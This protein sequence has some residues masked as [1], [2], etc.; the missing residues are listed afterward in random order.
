MNA[1]VIAAI[2]LGPSSARVLYHAAGFAR[3][4]SA[5]L[6]VLHVS[7]DT[8]DGERQRVIDYCVSEGP[9][10]LDPETADIVVRAGRVSDIIHREAQ[11]AGAALVVM[12][13]RGRSNLSAML[14]GSTSE[15]FLRHAPAP[16]LLVPPIDIDIVNISDRATLTC[17]P[18]L[19]A[20]D[21]AEAA[22]DQ[23]GL[24]ETCAT[25]SGQ[26]LLLM[27]VAPAR[28]GDHDAGAMLRARADA[29]SAVKPH[30]MIVRRGN[31]AREI[32]HCAAHEGAGLVVMGLRPKARGTPGAIASA[33]LKTRRAFVLAVPAS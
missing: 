13:S 19:A 26:P 16:V 11:R 20:I 22:G 28:L 30:A 4:L 3:L 5:R 33:V 14:L 32:S 2:D 15:A 12:G 29:L 9:Y 6:R 31:V 8:S 23:L 17:G 7:S 1:V 21:L 25:L 27:T 10:E 24:A 18:I